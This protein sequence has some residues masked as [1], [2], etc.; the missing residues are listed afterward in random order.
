MIAKEKPPYGGFS[1]N[2][3][4]EGVVGGTGAGAGFFAILL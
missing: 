4:C 3:A 2:Y 1:F